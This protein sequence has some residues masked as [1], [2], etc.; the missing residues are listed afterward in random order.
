MK[1]CTFKRRLPS[2]SI[3]WGYSIDA[4][5]DE[6]GKRKQI[7]KSG[8]ARKCDADDA[9]RTILNEKAADCELTKP[10]PQT[11]GAFADEWFK[12]YAPRKCSPKT[13]ERYRQLAD[14]VQP[15][16]GNAK[17]QDITAL[18]LER[19]F[20]RLKDA[21][22]WDRKKKQAKPLSA[23]TV[24][25]IAGLVNVILNKA[26]K[27]KLLKVNPMPGVE[28][29]PV[30]HHEAHAIDSGK[31]NWYLEASR[32]HGLYELMMFAAATGCR[33][34]ETLALPWSNLDLA[35]GAARIARSLEQTKEGLRLKTTKTERTRMISLPASLVA[36]LRFHRERQE[37]TRKMF[38]PDYRADLDL[39]FCNPDGDFL[40]PDS[41]TAK[42]CLIARKAGLGVG[43]GLHTLRHSHASQ[44]LHD[45]VPLPT[46]SK[47]LGHADVYTT[48][49][50]YAHA[51]PKDD[52]AAADTWD[53]QFKKTA[54]AARTAKIS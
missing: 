46:V 49:K 40:K 20:N 16:I 48:A 19:V 44:L 14:Y 39:V 47:R 13:R 50:I 1:G 15:H 30:P 38:G 22:G 29:P 7:F 5:K 27:L 45:G 2:G 12:E 8:F 51:L 3:T 37:Q 35:H 31:I 34:G 4:G 52:A 36:L 10:E 54:T 43:I 18:M 28:L 11:F 41:V 23:K 42:A 33:R 53:A 32:A 6:H 24:H 21:G 9:L 26:V 17:I 25:H